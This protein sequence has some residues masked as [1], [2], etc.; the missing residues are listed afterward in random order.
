MSP[1]CQPREWNGCPPSILEKQNWCTACMMG[2]IAPL[3]TMSSAWQP[4]CG[5]AALEDDYLGG[6]SR[7]S[8]KVEIKNIQ[9]FFR[10]DPLQAEVSLGS[11]DSVNALA[12]SLT[13]MTDEIT[14]LAA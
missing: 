6:G 9:V 7:G 2:M 11:F 10:K 12:S 5:L 8:G 3:P 14:R 13:S 1:R 4:S